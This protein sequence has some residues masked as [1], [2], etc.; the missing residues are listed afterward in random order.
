MALIK[1]P[2]CGK[3][4]SDKASRCPHCGLPQAYFASVIEKNENSGIDY[5]NLGNVLISFDRD[6]CEQFG[7]DHYIS[8]R[9]A[10]CCTIHTGLITKR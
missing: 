6:Y 7:A 4:I 3:E 10:G 5:K 1:C 2:E 8:Y 9:D